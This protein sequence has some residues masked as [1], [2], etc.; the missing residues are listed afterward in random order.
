MIRKRPKK[1]E[2][3]R[4]EN[5]SRRVVACFGPPGVGVSTVLEVLKQ[6]SNTPIGIVP[7]YGSISLPHIE[8]ALCHND[9]VLLDVDSGFFNAKDVQLL[10][11]EG[12]L[13]PR[14]GAVVRLYS[15]NQTIMKR[16]ASADRSDH[17]STEEID[18]W[19]LSCIGT[20]DLIRQHSLSYFMIPNHDLEE[21]VTQLAIR[22][23]VSD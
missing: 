8:E 23:G 13:G 1:V 22:I 17:I 19:N 3:K 11:D 4:L 10:V 16:L 5:T 2:A 20:E 18:F 6:A 12:H 9:V 21:A 15:E 7:Y 14:I